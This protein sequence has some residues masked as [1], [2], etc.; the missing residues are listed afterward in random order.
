MKFSTPD[1]DNDKSSTNCAASI[2]SGWWYNN[3]HSININR[4]TPQVGSSVLF[5]EIKI[6][7]KD[8]IT[9]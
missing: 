9:Q 1:N 2:K 6:R 4:Q 5:T 7:P 3:C 8:C